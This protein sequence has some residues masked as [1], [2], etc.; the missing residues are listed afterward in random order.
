MPP[1]KGSPQSWISQGMGSGA[2]APF[3]LT[4]M[5]GRPQWGALTSAARQECRQHTSSPQEE[6]SKDVCEF[7]EDHIQENL[8]VSWSHCLSTFLPL[9]TGLSCPWGCCVCTELPG[10]GDEGG[11]LKS[12]VVQHCGHHPP[13]SAH[14]GQS[15]GLSFLPDEPREPGAG[16]RGRPPAGRYN[17]APGF[18]LRGEPRYQAQSLG[19]VSCL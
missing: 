2:L 19:E 18:A 3:R 9:P 6:L 8:P 7:M 13:H 11:S 4:W 15:P 5:H 12:Q 14:S 17:Q 10:V 1:A 16:F